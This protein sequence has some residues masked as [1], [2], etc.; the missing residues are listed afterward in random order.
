M[1]AIP[2]ELEEAARIDGASELQIFFGIILP[3]VRPALATVTV[4]GFI[5]IWDQYLL[6]LIV[7]NREQLY[8][9]PVVLST[10]RSDETIRPNVFI[11]ITLVAMLPSIV[12][13]LSLQK[14]FSRGL[15][16]GAVKG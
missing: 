4:F 15:M 14:A 6:P 16:T 1:R 12:M 13:Y 3:L 2:V 9:L 5:M 10:L 8:T 7:T 11:A